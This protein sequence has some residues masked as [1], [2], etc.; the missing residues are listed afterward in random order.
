MSNKKIITQWPQR[1]FGPKVYAMYSSWVDGIILDINLMTVPIDDHLVHRGDGVF[2]AIK[3]IRHSPYLLGEHLAR[4]KKSGESI[5]I[6]IPNLD[7]IREIIKEILQH[8]PESCLVRVFVSRGPGGFGV[9]PKECVGPQ[10]YIVS[11][12]LLPPAPKYYI[13]GVKVG[14]SKFEAKPGFFAGI[15]SCNYLLNVLMKQEALDRQL[16]Y[17]IGVDAEGHLTESSTENFI[18]LTKDGILCH[19][20][21]APHGQTLAGTTMQRLFDLV[22][23]K[24]LFPTHRSATI[25]AE[26]LKKIRSAMMVGTTIDILPVAQ[27]E[28]EVLT[29]GSDVKILRELILNNQRNH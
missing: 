16:D 1:S 21:L 22:E 11:A 25:N 12:E 24:N 23:E 10:V 2:E 9:S 20:P 29:V 28:Q 26:E 13:E 17:C 5:G 4:L 19:P 7:D 8:S 27:I 15:K 3:V 18:W 6:K 14:I